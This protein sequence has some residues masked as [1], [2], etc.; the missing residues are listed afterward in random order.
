M[1]EEDHFVNILTA[2]AMKN[3]TV[4][5][6]MTSSF[7]CDA[8]LIFFPLLLKTNKQKS[9]ASFQ[10]PRCFNESSFLSN[11]TNKDNQF[12]KTQGSVFS[13]LRV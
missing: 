5:L 4:V 12:R 11:G 3:I 13:H 10:S 2:T 1:I 8:F 6:Q 9:L 7:I